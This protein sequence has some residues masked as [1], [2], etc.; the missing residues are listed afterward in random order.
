MSNP[1][2]T[3]RPCPISVD[4]LE[5]GWTIERFLGLQRL[6]CLLDE[7]AEW[8]CHDEHSTREIYTALFCFIDPSMERQREGMRYIS[9]IMWDLGYRP[10]ESTNGTKNPVWKWAEAS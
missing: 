5:Y 6:H 2:R 4:V 1:Y 3:P 9:E 10:T 8:L 7:N